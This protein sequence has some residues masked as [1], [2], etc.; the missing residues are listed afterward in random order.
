MKGEEPR[1]RAAYLDIYRGGR[2][3][4]INE[5]ARFIPAEDLRGRVH[6]SV[7]LSALSGRRPLHL[8]RLG[9]SDADARAPRPPVII[10]DLIK[11]NE[12]SNGTR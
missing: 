9:A 1:A 5:R 2:G 10:V 3:G 11:V 12:P 7:T 6:P 8:L 4:F